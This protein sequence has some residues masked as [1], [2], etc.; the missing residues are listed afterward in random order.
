MRSLHSKNHQHRD[1]VIEAVN[2]DTGEVR[3]FANGKQC[4]EA[5]GCSSPAVYM[6][7]DRARENKK[8]TI[9]GWILKWTKDFKEDELKSLKHERSIV[10]RTVRHGKTSERIKRLESIIENIDESIVKR[11]KRAK[12]M[13][14]RSKRRDTTVMFIDHLRQKK[15]MLESQIEEIVALKFKHEDENG[16]TMSENNNGDNK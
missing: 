5:I 1:E 10:A 15:K 13:N 4:A 6:T 2:E 9:K 3:H 7:L 14:K 8:A 16:N 12:K 11:K